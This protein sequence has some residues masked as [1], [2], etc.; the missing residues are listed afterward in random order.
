LAKAIG[1]FLIKEQNENSTPEVRNQSG[2]TLR[3]QDITEEDLEKMKEGGQ[4]T[5]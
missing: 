5:N 2:K 1:G 3:R 4:I